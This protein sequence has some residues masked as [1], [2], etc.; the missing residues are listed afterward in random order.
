MSPWRKRY[1]W[2]KSV[3]IFFRQELKNTCPYLPTR[4]LI[5]QFFLESFV[6]PSFALCSTTNKYLTTNRWVTH[7]SA[8]RGLAPTWRNGSRPSRISLCL[9]QNEL[10]ST[11]MYGDLSNQIQSCSWD[12]DGRVCYWD[13]NLFDWLSI[14]PSVTTDSLTLRWAIYNWSSSILG[15]IGHDVIGM[16]KPLMKHEFQGRFRLSR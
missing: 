2:R 13:D 6:R 5:S 16:L 12:E 4:N 14:N 1:Y 3:L 15:K 7:N 10:R 8:P 11:F 9:W